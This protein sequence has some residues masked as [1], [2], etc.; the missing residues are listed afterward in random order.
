V[1]AFESPKPQRL[2]ASFGAGVKDL[3]F[4]PD[5]RTL[6]VA[7]SSRT[8][9][10]FNI[11]SGVEQRPGL[12]HDNIVN[13][14]AFSPDGRLLATAGSD[15]SLRVWDLKS[16]EPA[17]A[18]IRREVEF[19]RVQFSPDGSFILAGPWT[20]HVQLWNTHAPGHASTGEMLGRP[21]K[22]ESAVYRA[23]FSPDGK[24]LATGTLDGVARVWDIASGLT[25]FAARLHQDRV[26]HVDFL[27]DGSGLLTAGA[28]GSIARTPIRRSPE[29]PEN[30]LP[31]LAEAIGGLRLDADRLLQAV[32][33][34]DYPAALSTAL[35]SP[36]GK[37]FKEWRLPT[38]N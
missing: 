37:V 10:L 27:D 2:R 7:G 35:A 26:L 34:N 14:L 15:R 1:F 12:R 19:V 13:S 28:D 33:R 11:G 17:R 6:A 9:R 36:G 22:H 23:K 29:A 31:D 16:R 38:G 18:P 20:R 8:V 32:P 4:S 24:R 5:N 25:V 21:L 30:W 3:R